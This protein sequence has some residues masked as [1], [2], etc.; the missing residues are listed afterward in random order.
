ML[1]I[2]VQT[3]G[4]LYDETMELLK[5]AGIKL[6]FGKRMLLLL[7]RNFPLEILFLRDSD[8]P[9][10]VASGMVDAGIVGLYE[11]SEKNKY[12][13]IVL[14]LEFDK[15]RLS[16]SIP[17]DEV[18]EG[19]DWFKNKTIATPYPVILR[20]FL[21]HNS[22]DA[23][24]HLIT[25]SVEVVPGIGLADAIFDIVNTGSTLASNR[26][27]EVEVVMVSEAVLIAN[28]NLDEAKQD[29]LKQ[30]V[31]RIKAVQKAKDKKYVLMNVPKEHL[32]EVLMLLP[33]EKNTT[34]IPNE[35]KAWYSVHTVMSEKHVWAIADK[36]KAIGV[37]DILVLNIEK[38]I[39]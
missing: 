38:M 9:E 29:I 32:K 19:L 24:V 30:F 3:K 25:G 34:T 27:K 23:E 12:V 17:K 18:Y 4:L 36:L 7:A 2:A 31:F 21:Q 13:N 14:P 35:D 39:P 10:S 22:L 26:L 11:V 8:I 16:L 6:S 33:N 28:P 37:E 1:R 5:E 20:E 15:C